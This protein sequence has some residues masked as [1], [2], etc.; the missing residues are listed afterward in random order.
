[1]KSVKKH[2]RKWHRRVGITIAILLLNLS[3]TG[4]ILNHYEVL[5]LHKKMITSS[6]LLDWYDVKYPEN[7]HCLNL[8]K[9]KL[10][11]VDNNIYRID[12][13]LNVTTLIREQADLINIYR[14]PSEIIVVTNNSLVIFDNEF[15][16]ID[17]INVF[18]EI[19]SYITA[20]SYQNAQLFLQTENQSLLVDLNSLDIQ[21]I[22]IKDWPSV[23]FTKA[24]LYYL[25]DEK[26]KIS[27]GQAY[28]QKQI[29]QL[30]FI[31]DLHSG[32]LFFR[33]GKFLTDLVAI[34]TIFLV[35]S[36]LITWQ[37]RKA[38]TN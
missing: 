14:S 13:E 23:L 29:S 10:C 9:N 20:S 12:N 31:Q 24:N 7:I 1:M 17:S 6:W 36:S 30:K 33:T 35:F 32:Q 21:E 11:S 37:T 18:E 26:L 19:F 5:S 34:L 3:I 27:I 16:L 15:V 22:N 38:K 28:R 8:D 4:L 2:L 25:E